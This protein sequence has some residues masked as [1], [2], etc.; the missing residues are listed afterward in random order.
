ML[1]GGGL[2]PSTV[3]Q[4]LAAAA[5]AIS[6]VNVAGGFLVSQRMIGLFRRAT[7]PPEH[8]YLYAL[9]A[10]V[11]LTGFFAARAAGVDLGPVASLAAGGSCIAAIAALSSQATA[12]L[13][14]A[15]GVV[16]VTCGLVITLAAIAVPQSVYMQIAAAMAVGSAGGFMVAQR[17]G[18]SE[19]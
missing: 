2:L 18:P 7:D 5:V 19:L 8:N 14:N 9:P 12:A 13:G 1:C 3:P 10:A 11:F 15:L 6:M 16:G 17:V 4:Q